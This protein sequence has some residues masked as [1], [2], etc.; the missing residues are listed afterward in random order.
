MVIDC[1]ADEKNVSQE[2]RKI[3]KSQ[4]SRAIKSIADS[5]L[6]FLEDKYDTKKWIV[7]VL[8][9]LSENLIATHGNWSGITS[10]KWHYVLE[11]GII[12]LAVSVNQSDWSKFVYQS[13]SNFLEKFDIP[14]RT[15]PG[16][17]FGIPRYYVNAKQIHEHLNR[18][19]LPLRAK[20]RADIQ[21]LV[22]EVDPAKVT[23]TASNGTEYLRLS[24]QFNCCHLVMVVIKSSDSDSIPAARNQQICAHSLTKDSNEP[25]LLRNEWNQA[26]LSVYDDRNQESLPII[27]DRVWRNSSGQRWRFVNDQLINDHNQCL[28]AWTEGSSLLYQYDCHRDW[29]GQIWHRNGLQIVN[30]YNLCLD[31]EDVTYD[32]TMR[33]VQNYCDSTPSFLWA[34][35]DTSCEDALVPPPSGAGSRSFRNE[36]SR[37]YLSVYSDEEYV[38]DKPWNHSPGKNWTFV[39]DTL[40][41]GFGKCLIGKGWYVQQADCDG[42]DKAKRW[43]L[44]EKRQIVSA[45]GYCLGVGDKEGYVS[46]TYCKDSAA[47]R[48]WYY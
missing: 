26:Y 36:F 8:P 19:L 22:V 4:T 6:N 1:Q 34:D 5:L 23:I 25:G 30:G 20:T 42:S 38:F 14:I 3:M 35:W 2:M 47:Y 29:V 9:N 24:N 21:T 32:G 40:R 31:Y 37:R 28:T 44:N 13:A 17:L 12:A 16:L 10:E 48:W 27:L 39:D 41:N 7:V 45:E 46:Y 18:F 15:S 11:K 33:V 43:T